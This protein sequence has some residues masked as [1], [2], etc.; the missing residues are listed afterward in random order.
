MDCGE[1]GILAASAAGEMIRGTSSRSNFWRGRIWT[2]PLTR[3]S[4]WNDSLNA[5]PCLPGSRRT[6]RRAGMGGCG[7]RSRAPLAHRP[8]RGTLN[9]AAGIPLFCVTLA[10]Y[11]NGQPLLAVIAEPLESAILWAVQGEGA[12]RRNADGVDEPLQP[13]GD[14]LE[15]LGLA[16]PAGNRYRQR[17]RPAGE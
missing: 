12:Y 6:C 3:T 13:Q 14:F 7:P 1:T 8:V 5:D 9:F 4:P 10:F 11:A 2:S 15:N 17:G 16:L